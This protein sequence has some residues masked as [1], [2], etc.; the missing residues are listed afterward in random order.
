MNKIYK[1]KELL[2]RSRVATLVAGL[3]FA[4]IVSA[5]FLA[6]YTTMMGEG[7]VLQSVVFGNGD[8]VKSYTIGDSPAIAGNTYIENY[9]LLNRSETTA[10]IKFVTNQC[11]VGGGHCAEESYDED[12]VNTSYWSSV[13]LRSK[14]SSTWAILSDGR[15]GTLTY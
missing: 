3:L 9:N 8:T 12:G 2:Q 7:D 11:M 6:I 4:G 14:D 10:P 13:E 5:G 15:M 1:I